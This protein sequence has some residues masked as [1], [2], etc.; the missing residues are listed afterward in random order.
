MT[1]CGQVRESNCVACAGEGIVKEKRAV[2]ENGVLFSND[3]Q[4][5]AAKEARY[6][7]VRERIAR[8]YSG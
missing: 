3:D 1:G 4:S 5:E 6:S 7:V 2:D 8:M